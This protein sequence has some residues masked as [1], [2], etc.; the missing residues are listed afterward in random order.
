[1]KQHLLGYFVAL[2]WRLYAA[3]RHGIRFLQY[4]SCPTSQCMTVSAFIIRAV[5]KSSGEHRNEV[6]SSA[7]ESW[8]GA[9]I[10]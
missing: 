10:D 7:C 3:R 6:T 2:L 9:C 1:M 8:K 4:T 5:V